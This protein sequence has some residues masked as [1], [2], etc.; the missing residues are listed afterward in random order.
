MLEF[1]AQSL[2]GLPGKD[3]EKQNYVNEVAIHGQGTEQL[4]VAACGKEMAI[5][6]LKR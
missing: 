3:E 1:D 4:L 2:S 5:F 6:S